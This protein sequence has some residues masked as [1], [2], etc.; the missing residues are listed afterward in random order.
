MIVSGCSASV[1]QQPLSLEERVQQSHDAGVAW[2][3]TSLRKDKGLFRY[4]YHPIQDEASTKQN[5]LRQMMASRLLAELAAED[6]SFLADHLRNLEFLFEHWYREDGDIGY[7]VYSNKSK[8]GGN[9]MALRML[10]W[11]PLFAE[12]SEQAEKIANSIVSLIGPDGAMQPWLVEPDYDYDPERL[13]TF[14]SGEAILA[15][16]EYAKKTGSQFYWDE[17]VRAQ[18]YYIDRYVTHM[19]ENYYPAYVPWHTQSLR[20][21]YDATGDSRYADAIFA[22]NDKLLEI[23]DTTEYIGRFYNPATPQYGT[24]HS[25]SDAVYMEGLAHAYHVAREAEDAERAM[26]Y[27]VAIELA[28]RNLETLQYTAHNTRDYPRPKEVIGALQISA[29]NPSIRIDTT[30]HMLDGYRELLRQQSEL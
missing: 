27:A 20:I 11:S 25:S 22:L 10:V 7:M 3:R 2:F 5:E 24:P 1:P 23:Q 15:L 18:G 26:R 28:V 8:L 12:Y 4:M 17:A 13:L 19:E 30:Q 21:L 14:Y 16:L 9:A 6:P 29:R